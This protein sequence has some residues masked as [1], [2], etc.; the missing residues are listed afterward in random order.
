VLH[1]ASPPVP[2]AD[3]QAVLDHKILDAVCHFPQSF[4]Q[5]RDKVSCTAPE[6]F[7]ALKRLKDQGQLRMEGQLYRLP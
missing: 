1:G 3:A 2:P 5:I 7:V 4:G 6:L